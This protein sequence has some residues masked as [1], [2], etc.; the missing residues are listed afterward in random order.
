MRDWLRL[1]SMLVQLGGKRMSVLLED[2][3]S[4][5]SS[6]GRFEGWLM[7]IFGRNALDGRINHLNVM[8]IF[9]PSDR[10]D[11]LLGVPYNQRNC[12]FMQCIEANTVK[13]VCVNIITAAHSLVSGNGHFSRS[14]RCVRAHKSNPMHGFGSRNG[15]ILIPSMC[16]H[17][18]SLS[19]KPV[20]R[21]LLISDYRG[22]S[23]LPVG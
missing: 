5:S 8:R 10:F 21:V 14:P 4:T 7:K 2:E 19:P 12:G 20:H 3:D 1:G 6:G 23:D 18:A 15:R 13:Q 9:A 17:L 11:G 22:I 16:C